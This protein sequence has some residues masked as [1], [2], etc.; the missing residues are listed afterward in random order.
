MANSTHHKTDNN[1]QTWGVLGSYEYNFETASGPKSLKE[2][3]DGR[4]QLILYHF[5]YGPDWKEGCPSCSYW[6]DNFD[7]IDAHLAHRDITLA[8]VSSAPLDII[9]AYRDRMGWQFEWVSA[10]GSDFNRDMQVS[11][12]Q[13]EVDAGNAE[14]NYAPR[15]FPST[16]AP[17]I[18]VWQR[19][20]D[21]IYHTYGTFGRGLDMLNGAYHLMDIAPK[22]RD[23]GNLPWPM[24]WLRRRDQYDDKAC[25]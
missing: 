6:G 8:F 13:A 1:T 15:G 25:R 19:E 24:A 5:M 18:T 3:F 2:L 14:Y 10:A 11:F 9:Q 12:T 20:G 17:G 22:G 4:S 16:E 7:G 23:E 21:K